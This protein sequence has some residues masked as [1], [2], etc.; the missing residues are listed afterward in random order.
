MRDGV[1]NLLAQFIQGGMRREIPMRHA[2][3]EAAV[4]LLPGF[5]EG[6]P[7]GPVGPVER[8]V[9]IVEVVVEIDLVSA[10]MEDIENWRQEKDREFLILEILNIIGK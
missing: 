10:D 7:R 4:G 1:A 6:R 8:L 3:D 9:R 5:G 2:P